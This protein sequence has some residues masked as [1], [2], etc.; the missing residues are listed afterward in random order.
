[1]PEQPWERYAVEEIVPASLYS[2]CCLG[3]LLEEGASVGQASGLA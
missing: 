2:N 3:V 1:M